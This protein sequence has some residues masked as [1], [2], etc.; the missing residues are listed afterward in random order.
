MAKLFFVRSLVLA[1]LAAILPWVGASPAAAVP[2]FDT[3]EIV[4]R[5]ASSFNGNSGTPNPFTSVDLQARVTAPSGRAY[6]V[7]GFFDGD[8]AS[9]AVGNVFKIRI[10]ADEVGTWRW[11]TTSN[12]AGLQGQSGSFAVSGTLAGTFGKGPVVPNPA[13][14]RS[15]QYQLGEPVYLIGKFLDAAAP[16]ALRYS[17]TLFS[18]KITDSTRSSMLSRHTG[19]RLNKM[20]VYLA[21]RGDYGGISTTPWVG[22]ATSNDKQRFDLQ[23]W[24]M[25][26]QWTRRLRDSGLV[27]QLWFFADDSAFGDL[28]EADRKRLI[29]YGMARLS[30][31]ANTMFTLV[32]EWE[33]G[34]TSA[35]LD[36]HMNYLHSMNPWARL[37]SIHGVPGDFTHPGAAWAD[38]MDTQ[39]GNEVG[40]RTVHEHG[41]RNRNL[42]AKPLIQEEFGE[43]LEDTAHRQKAWAAFTAG[44]AGSGTGAFL[45]PLAQFTAQVDFERMA[46]ADS[47]ALSGNAYVLA[48]AGQT[49]VAYLYDGGTLRLNLSGTTGTFA[50]RWFDPR[51]G[52]FRDAGSVAAGQEARFTAPA[53]GDWT[54]LLTR[55]GTAPAPSPAV[56]RA[57]IAEALVNAMRGTT[58]TPPAAS[59]VFS[60]VP[61]SHWAA[62]DIEQIFRDRLTGGCY[63]SP[64]RFCPDKQLSRAEMAVLLLLAKHGAAYRPPAAHGGIFQ[65]VPASHWAAAW[66]EQFFAEGLTAGCGT[67]PRRYCPDN[68]VTGTELQAFLDSIF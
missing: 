14:P 61:V 26:E 60:D 3:A 4:L 49:Y 48:E 2:R 23:R 58:F 17:H 56:T 44:A 47:L 16:S 33:E 1:G 19:M 24:R 22:T 67:N 36:S 11:S 55:S 66:I 45:A 15:F 59:G 18:E 34:W 63:S 8:G 50:A 20:N 40:H 6:T 57:Q 13:R 7:D 9:G 10:F 27:A 51:T 12:T 46:P 68:S 64:L 65:D 29:R 21:N 37:A 25:Y 31:Y 28:P 43:G 38:Y 62:R 5:S 52:A 32:L 42:I 54:L 41:L 39:A 35:E 53:S 30:G